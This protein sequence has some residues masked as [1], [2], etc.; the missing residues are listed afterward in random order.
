MG[1]RRTPSG[2]PFHRSGASPIIDRVDRTALSRDGLALPAPPTDHTAL[3]FVAC[4]Q[5]IPRH[6]VRIVDE[7]GREVAER[8]EGRLQFTGP[9]ATKGY[10]RNE[11]KNRTL[12][13]GEWLESGDRAYVAKGDIYITGRI[14]DM[15]IKAGRHIYPHEIE[16]LV[17]G[18]EGVRKGCVVAF[19][20][21]GR[22]Q[23]HGALG[24]AGLRPASRMLLLGKR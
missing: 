12:F 5:P 16:E 21:T 22:R 14:K 9:S 11:E 18:I 19:P 7:S 10:F 23:G 20:T 3:E 15:I 2:S 8:T 17:G 13:D 24:A 4:G 1:W 6:E